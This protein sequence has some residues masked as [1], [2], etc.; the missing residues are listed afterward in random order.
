MKSNIV[1]QLREALIILRDYPHIEDILDSVSAQAFLKE[2]SKSKIALVPSFKELDSEKTKE[3][4]QHSKN[5][6]EEWE[7]VIDSVLTV[8]LWNDE[9]REKEDIISGTMAVD[10]AEMVAIGNNNYNNDRTAY[11]YFRA[12]NYAVFNG[13]SGTWVEVYFAMLEHVNENLLVPDLPQTDQ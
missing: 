11:F 10:L 4:I 1:D 3:F 8:K 6:I 5:S 2:L 13:M 7:K 12:N 9:L